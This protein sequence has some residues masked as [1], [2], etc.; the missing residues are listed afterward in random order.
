MKKA[1][2][3]ALALC[4]LLALGLSACGTQPSQDDND[5]PTDAKRVEPLPADESLSNPTDAEVAASFLPSSLREEGGKLVLEFTVY[6]YELF[7]SVDVSA[8]AVGDTLVVDGKD[9][10]VASREDTES[11]I[12]SI[13]GGLEN[14]GVDLAPGDG[15]TYYVIGL[16]D[17]KDY[18]EVATVK[19]PVD[20]NCVLTDHSNLE[21]PDQQLSITEVQSMSDEESHFV[22]NNTLIL[23]DNGTVTAITRNYMP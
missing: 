6:D 13:N 14:G 19:L 7:D 11:G 8:L 9:M 2:S 12:V 23:I 1:L 4:M 15:G 21:E 5:P 3:L 22:P 17:A 20:P 18:Q 10:T 16:D